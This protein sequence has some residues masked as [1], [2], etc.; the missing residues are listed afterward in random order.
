M[1]EITVTQ[2]KESV[3]EILKNMVVAYM[4]FPTGLFGKGKM[5]VAPVAEDYLHDYGICKD[6]IVI[7]RRQDYADYGQIVCGLIGTD[8]FI[9]HYIFN[10]E[11]GIPCLRSANPSVEDAYD[12][13]IVGTVVWV[14]RRFENITG[15]KVL[16]S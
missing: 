1:T 9:R 14:I 10:E 7:F 11:K 4:P 16:A 6:D 12:F 3:E 8:L 15:K 2:T 5:F 13:N